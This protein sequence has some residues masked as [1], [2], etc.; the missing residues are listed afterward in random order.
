MQRATPVEP[1]PEQPRWL[2]ALADSLAEALPRLHNVSAEPLLVELIGALTQALADG[3]LEIALP[4]A[5]HRQALLASPLATEPHGPLVLDGDRLLWRRWQQ[6]RQAV[7]EALLQR[8]A[9][10]LAEQAPTGPELKA[11]LMRHGQGLDGQQ[12]AAVS[13]V[14][15]CPVV[16]LEGGPGTGKTS[17]VSRMLAAVLDHWPACRIQLA[18]PTGKAAARLRSALGEGQWPCGTLHRLL[19]SRG[20]RFG[21]H[22]SRPLELDLLV[23]DEVSMLDVPLAG[24]LLKALPT[25][26]RLV[27]VGDAAQL[28]PV[29]PGSL[30]RD[31]QRHDC[32][33]ALGAGA[34]E[35]RRTYRNNGAIAQ[36]AAALRQGSSALEPLLSTLPPGANLQWLQQTP[37]RLPELLLARLRQHQQELQQLAAAGEPAPVLAALERC[38]VLSPLRRGPWGVMA[39][40]RALLGELALR[41][42]QAWPPGTPVLCPQN[43]DELGL[44]NGDLGVVMQQ[45]GELRLLFCPA[46]EPLLLHPAQLPAAQPAL[47]LTV[48]KAQGSEADEV[49]VLLDPAA[50]QQRP[51]LYTA[52]TR[53]RQQAWLISAGV[54]TLE[55]VTHHGGEPER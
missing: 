23:I 30:L 21:R 47:A 31:L 3:E 5:A 26:A 53:A 13:A 25:H 45:Q 46:G 15:R 35:L 38:L 44:A 20:D 42:P 4:S 34:V 2:G 16:L 48:H 18:A 50:R 54:P 43:L 9:Q 6:Q 52:L 11:L 29:G 32:R 17:T 10:P 37:P 39:I 19:E 8:A 1:S 41:S 27:L 55:P 33:Q 7:R 49:W 12:Q 14:L 36:V 51:L 40:H 24:A 28:P 22:S